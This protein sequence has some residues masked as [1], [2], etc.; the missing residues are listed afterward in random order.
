V[1]IWAQIR[2]RYRRTAA[3]ALHVRP[4]PINHTGPIISFTFDDFPRSA[5]YTGGA[6]LKQ[7]GTV[8]TYYASLG[9]MGKVAPTGIMFTREDLQQ[10]M[11]Q[12]HE[13]GCH[14]YG[15]ADAW[16]TRP[17]A[18][19]QSVI[20]NSQALSRLA[21][22]AAFRTMSYPINV[23]RPLT[24]LKMS[25]RFACCRAGGQHFNAGVLDLNHLAAFFL[26][27]T[28]GDAD[29]VQRLIEENQRARGW[30]IFAT[31]DVSST[32]T[33]WGCLPE[34]FETVVRQA[35]DSGA[36]VLPV[37]KALEAIRTASR[38]ENQ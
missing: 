19:E 20:Q 29:V 34:F 9:L 24:K 7:L 16:E 28:K 5:L 14:T 1:S 3:K 21:P 23:P 25:A 15:H 26:E 22:G 37:L 27:K 18:F 38:T 8:G 35:V 6:I 11:E 31:H 33:P 12:G 10:L 32:P 30:L 17:W 13:L 2:S 36:Q 4:L